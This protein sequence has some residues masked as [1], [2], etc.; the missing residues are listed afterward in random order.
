M[1]FP[2]IIFWNTKVIV[3]YANWYAIL[4]FTTIITYI[5]IFLSYI[6]FFKDYRNSKK[7]SLNHQCIHLVFEFFQYRYYY[8]VYT[9]YQILLFAVFYKTYHNFLY[10]H[11]NHK[12]F[13]S[14]QQ[15]SSVP[16]K[17]LVLPFAEALQPPHKY[18]FL[19]L[20][21]FP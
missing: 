21:H 2:D 13:S 17:S 11:E 16:N 6:S 9:Y 5:Y 12:S 19:H 4:V 14:N 3:Y 10:A 20:P 1:F 7:N 8:I 15:L 18:F